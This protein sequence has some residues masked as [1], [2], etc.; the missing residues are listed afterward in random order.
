[1]LFAK[2]MSDR[3]TTKDRR[4]RNARADASCWNHDFRRASARLHIRCGW[5]PQDHVGSDNENDSQESQKRAR[6]CRSL[7]P[8]LSPGI[9]Q[10]CTSDAVGSP[11]TMS[12]QTTERTGMSEG[13]AQTQVVGTMTFAGH[14]PDLHIRC[15]WFRQECRIGQLKGQERQ[16]GARRR[17]SLEP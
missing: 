12:D 7:G 15:G 10:T 3:K 11:K 9:G 16:R 5:F 2:D 8:S 17:K 4:V 14:R 13:R 6:E 1:M